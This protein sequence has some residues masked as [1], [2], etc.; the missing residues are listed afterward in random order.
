M[1]LMRGEGLLLV[2]QQELSLMGPVNRITRTIRVRLYSTRAAYH[3]HFQEEVNYQ[4]DHHQGVSI[5]ELSGHFQTNQHP[6]KILHVLN[7]QSYTP[8][9]APEGVIDSCLVPV[10][11]GNSGYLRV[12]F[13]GQ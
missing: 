13:H 6:E 2:S 12:C 3:T 11:M 9:Y 8:I 4:Y 7:P 5:A 1:P 10:L